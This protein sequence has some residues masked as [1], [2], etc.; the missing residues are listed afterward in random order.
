VGSYFGGK[1]HNTIRF[2]L[3][4]IDGIPTLEGGNIKLNRLHQL[5]KDYQADI[6]ALTEL[7]MAWDKLPYEERLPYKTHGWW[8]ASHW[9]MSHNKKDKHGDTFQPVAQ[10]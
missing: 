5:T 2:I 1:T 3:Q 4:N 8:E 10:H 9:I 6:V 7:N